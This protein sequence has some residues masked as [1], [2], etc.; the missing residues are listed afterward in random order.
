MAK[1]AALKSDDL[2]DLI[3]NDDRV[4]DAIM[5]RIE[6]ILT[7]IM[8]RIMEK[9]S[10]SMT[11]KFEQVIDQ[12][13]QTLSA[14][15]KDINSTLFNENQQLRTKINDLE[16]H[17]RSGNLIIYGLAEK[18]SAARISDI[19]QHASNKSDQIHVAL[20]LFNDQMG[21]MV[22]NKD[23][24]SAYFLRSNGKNPH[25]PLLVQFNNPRARLSVLYAR[26]ELKNISEENSRIYINEHLTSLNASLFAE[27]RKLVKKKLLHAA[28]SREGRIY[29]KR[30]DNTAERPQRV[31][32]LKDLQPP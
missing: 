27:A 14:E 19:E 7:P 11:A 26:K 3:Q 23:I 13:F 1:K 21:L 25:R 10:V 6:T 12:K 30:S 18:T 8:E 24:A 32:S 5:V 16:T 4:M 17:Q 28:W 22:E 9:L 15:Q 2:I 29:V 31:N 20:A